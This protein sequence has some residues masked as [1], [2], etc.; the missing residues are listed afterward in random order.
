MLSAHGGKAILLLVGRRTQRVCVCVAVISVDGCADIL[1]VCTCAGE[2]SFAVPLPV[3]SR[4]AEPSADGGRGGP[5][6]LSR[7]AGYGQLA[8]LG[9]QSPSFGARSV[10]CLSMILTL[11]V[12]LP[13][14]GLSASADVPGRRVGQSRA[15]C[16]C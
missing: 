14:P 1:S 6:V 10:P 16:K 15:S 13:I 5:R 4:A 12:S 7:F 2:L 9:F 3:V 11:T 8:M